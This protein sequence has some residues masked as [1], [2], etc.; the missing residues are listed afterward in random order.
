M[1]LYK[2]CIIMIIIITVKDTNLNKKIKP[3]QDLQLIEDS[4]FK[5]T[6]AS[7]TLSHS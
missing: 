5:S 7:A 1:A 3:L 4:S 2:Y 6:T